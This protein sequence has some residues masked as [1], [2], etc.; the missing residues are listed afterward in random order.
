MAGVFRLENHQSTLEG[1]GCIN[2]VLTTFFIS[3]GEESSSSSP[4]PPHPPHPANDGGRPLLVANSFFWRSKDQ[5]YESPFFL[6]WPW[7]DPHQDDF[8]PQNGQTHPRKP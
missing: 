5:Q 8:L 3:P 6:K 4:S 1:D 2:S 7:R